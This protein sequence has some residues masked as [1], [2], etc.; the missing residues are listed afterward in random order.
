MSNIDEVYSKV[1]VVNPAVAAE[2]EV[3]LNNL[4]ALK[5][6]LDISSEL[7]NISNVTGFLNPIVNELSGI[8]SIENTYFDQIIN[9]NPEGILL[10]TISFE[11]TAI[12]LDEVIW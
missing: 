10:N 12:N 8:Y 4:L 5:G 1:S 6:T 11:S 2:D 9:P 3:N 7:I